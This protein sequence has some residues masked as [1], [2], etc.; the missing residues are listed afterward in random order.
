MVFR[1]TQG[2]REFALRWASQIE[3]G[4]FPHDEHALSWAF[5]SSPDVRFSYI[6]ERYSGRE[7]DQL[8][9]G[10][11]VHRSAYA[12]HRK[13]SRGLLRE[14]LRWIERPFRTGRTK[15]EKLQGLGVLVEA[16]KRGEAT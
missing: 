7:I 1:P 11:I 5:L 14:C 10:V 16:S 8:Q 15:A 9:D 3:R 6:D 12:Q 4:A 13:S 2:A